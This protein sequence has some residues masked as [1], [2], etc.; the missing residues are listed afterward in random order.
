MLQDVHDDQFWIE[1]DQGLDV[2]IDFL[3]LE[4]TQH[5][6]NQ[7]VIV[8]IDTA[9]VWDRCRF[10]LRLFKISLQIQTNQFQLLDSLGLLLSP[11]ENR[12]LWR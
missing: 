4:S 11:F 3:K 6:L 2:R 12:W 7:N 8:I 5:K 1:F 9:T 10:E